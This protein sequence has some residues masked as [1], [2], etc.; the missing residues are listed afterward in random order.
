MGNQN[1]WAGAIRVCSEDIT[2]ALKMVIMTFLPCTGS[3]SSWIWYLSWERSIPEPPM[4]SKGALVCT[5]LY[6]LLL[7]FGHQAA[8]SLFSTEPLML[9]KVF[10]IIKSSLSPAATSPWFL[11][12]CRDG[13]P[14]PPWETYYCLTALFGEEIFSVTQPGATWSHFFSFW[15]ALHH[16]LE[17]ICGCGPSCVHWAAPWAGGRS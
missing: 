8:V 14:T 12:T 11:N 1:G 13:D 17:M 7:S 10:R 4:A 9:E 5:G 15:F 6:W 16:R 2:P 3:W